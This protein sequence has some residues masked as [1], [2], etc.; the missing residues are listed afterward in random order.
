MSVQ[1]GI[2]NLDGQP[3]DR[4]LLESY[5]RGLA[6]YGPDGESTFFDGAIA[7]LHHEAISF[8]TE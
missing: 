3:V 2:W 1:A 7:M 4:T 8:L 5:S 6:E